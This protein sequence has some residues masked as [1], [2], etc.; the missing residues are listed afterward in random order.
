MTAEVTTPEA[1]MIW[2]M[3][4]TWTTRDLPV[5]DAIVQY[6]DTMKGSPFPDSFDDAP[7]TFGDI[8]GASPNL[9]PE[10]V[11]R[12]ARALDGEYIEVVWL[13]QSTAEPNAIA[14]LANT[15]RRA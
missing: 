14:G 15:A 11:L 8:M 10:Q 1:R 9:T 13:D 12:A 4:D 6:F 5:L 2:I 7:V 3:E